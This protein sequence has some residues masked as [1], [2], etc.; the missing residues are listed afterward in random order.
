VCNLNSNAF[1]MPM[2]F[3]LMECGAA[4]AANTRY[5]RRKN[6]THIK[7]AQAMC[8][9]KHIRYTMHSGVNACDRERERG[10][11]EREGGERERR[12][13]REGARELYLTTAA[14]VS[15]SA[16]H[17]NTS[18]PTLCRATDSKGF[19]MNI[20]ESWRCSSR[21]RTL[22]VRGCRPGSALSQ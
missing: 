10:G 1:L 8:S 19:V 12:E 20:H 4:S 5:R 15:T 17:A 21:K 16:W 22:S 14:D 3:F 11:R 2:I 18:L 6:N 13:R 7:V 9:H